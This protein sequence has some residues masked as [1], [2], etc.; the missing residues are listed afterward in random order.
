MRWG[1]ASAG[2][3]V[4]GGLSDDWS[5]F[6]SDP[7][8]HEKV[9]VNAGG[10]HVVMNTSPPGPALRHHDLNELTR[11][12]DRAAALGCTAYRFSVEWSRVEPAPG[13]FST[14]LTD[15]YVPA[16]LLM[17]ERG[18]E[19][20]VTLSHLTSPQW[21][22]T[23]S[24]TTKNF[25]L[26]V[27]TYDTDPGFAA[28]LRGWENPAT[29]T[30][31]AAFVDMVVAALAPAGARYWLTLNEPVGSVVGAGYF[32]SVW[33]P[34]FLGD[35]ARGKNVYFNLLRAHVTA[36]RTIMARDPSAQVGFAHNMVSLAPLGNDP[37]PARRYGYFFNDHFLNSL[38]TGV[39]DT[40]INADPQSQVL[41]QPG[42]FF[43]A[44]APNP[45]VRPFHFLGINFYYKARIYWD[46]LIGLKGGTYTGGRSDPD[47]SA[48]GITHEATGLL[49]GLGWEI[50]PDGLRQFLVDLGHKFGVPLVISEFGMSEP[51]ESL[52]APHLVAHA[53]AIEA[54]VG[55]GADVQAA[56]YWALCDNFEWTFNYE[57]RAKFGLFG[58]NRAVDAA[59]NLPLTRTMTD[60][61][62]AFRSLA[63]GGL[64]SAVGTRFGEISADGG[65]VTAVGASP[66]ATYDIRVGGV[67]YLL[68][69]SR[70]GRPTRD[71]DAL[72]YS[73]VS[74]GWTAAAVRRWDPVS[75][76]VTVELTLPGT[77]L[78][79]WQL[80]F[81]SD[82]LTASGQ[83]A[84][85]PQIA[86]VRVWWD[87]TYAG[88]GWFIR[89][90]LVPLEQPLGDPT[91]EV[92]IRRPGGPGWT[93]VSAV[94]MPTLG[95]FAGLIGAMPFAAT[96]TATA[97][98]TEPAC[99]LTVSKLAFEHPGPRTR[100]I[101]VPV[102]PRLPDHVMDCPP[103]DPHAARPGAPIQTGVTSGAEF[104]VVA[105][106]DS[107]IQLAGPGNTWRSLL[108]GRTAPGG[109]T[110]LASRHAGMLDFVTIGTDGQAYTAGRDE[111]D[112][113]GGWWL[114]PGFQTVPGA[115]ITI[116]SSR[117][118]ELVV[119]AADATGR[120]MQTT[121]TPG[122]AWQAWAQIQGGVT[123]PGGWISAASRHEGM[124]DFVTTGTD[125]QAYTAGRDEQGGWGGWW[126]LPGFQTIPG[127]AIN[128]LSPRLDELVV[129]AAD[130]A[131]RTMQ[132]TWTPASGWLAWAQIQG[133]VTAPGGW[134]SAAS[135][136]EG[137][138]D[139]VT[140][141]T[142]GRAYTAA[143]NENGAWGGWWLLSGFQ[144]TP[145]AVIVISS[146][147]PDQL[148]VTAVDGTGR[149][150]RT[151]WAPA[152]GWTLWT[153]VGG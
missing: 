136:H 93:T 120:T 118:D 63:C 42:Q 53:A 127:A 9:R 52:R 62:L 1:V 112:A 37:D 19:P 116:I 122:T 36:F 80:T 82:L 115:P 48:V 39:V 22:L 66:C 81:S 46:P 123:A 150:L 79:S 126:L 78:L 147:Q 70:P 43:G 33:S 149:I 138:L 119:S 143:R 97:T 27:E 16:V 90:R 15:Y 105:D 47:Q 75:R 102:L 140:I 109:W 107:Q 51:S 111:H 144:T 146:P 40:A 98:T 132:T 142:D 58:V 74:G 133:G 64:S 131:G 45:W 130:G 69:L 5:I 35:Y 88:G 104:T 134:V 99:P 7:A 141:G 148:S 117:L 28:S 2:H 12:L 152:T 92:R 83:V 32:A 72:V 95:Q 18:L 44:T 106:V 13:A 11:D 6:E 41:Q 113:L 129:S 59:G 124:L 49:T 60:G 94:S 23:P 57:P 128:V 3:Q 110:T 77:T 125:G 24:R 114:L 56:F 103:I 139:F 84:R 31:Y 86:G 50:N 17:R 145:G 89:L 73:F 87:G 71:M 76:A 30:F 91:I 137:M 25:G 14:A 108:G 151:G 34:G 21:V 101:T 26:F 10:G 67:R 54:A 96:V 55:A 68:V 38:A 4:E 20:Y 135:R 153:P 85:G 100:P 61:A 65:S 8:I 29:I 121:W